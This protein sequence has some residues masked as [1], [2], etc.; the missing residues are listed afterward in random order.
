MTVVELDPRAPARPIPSYRGRWRLVA[1][2]RQFSTALPV[3]LTE[4]TTARGRQLQT[5]WNA[6]AQLTFTLDGHAP[7]A[8]LLT[9]LATDV[10]AFRWD[11]PY[12]RDRP[13]FRG[14]IDHAEDQLS[15]QSAAVTFTCHDYSA[16]LSRRILT[17]PASSTSWTQT[18]QDTIATLLVNRASTLYASD[19]VT[20]FQPGSFLPLTAVRYNPDGTP[21]YTNSGQLR[22]RTYQPHQNIGDA[23]NQLALVINGF[24]YDVLPSG[25]NSSSDSLRLFYPQQGVA[26]TDLT[27]AYGANVSTV[28]RTVSSADYANYVRALGNN[29]SSDPMAAQLYGE[30]WNTDA[31]NVTVNPVG[32]WMTAENASDVTIQSTLLDKANGDLGWLGLLTPTYTL[33]LRPGAYAYGYPN[34]GDAVGLVINEGRLAVNTSVRVVGF[35]YTIGDDGQEDVALTVGRPPVTLAKLLSRADRDIDALARR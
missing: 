5:Q 21:R 17:A 24:D 9:E 6:P 8:A 10:V 4:L 1:Y 34:M 29:G 32:L 27:F 25:G 15:E 2:P 26:R 20:S 14:L 7:E 16:M 35:T 13:M 3:P 28:T 12:G 23:L 19:G 18:D 31:N 30:A 11:E 22:D 33:G